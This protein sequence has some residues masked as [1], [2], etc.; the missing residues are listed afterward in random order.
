MRFLHVE[1]D[2]EIADIVRRILS[3]KG[4]VH[5]VKNTRQA[6]HEIARSE[7]ESQKYDIVLLDLTLESGSDPEA[8]LSYMVERDMKV[9]I[10][11]GS[12]STLEDVLED[13][14]LK[15]V[16]YML[17][18]FANTSDLLAKID[19]LYSPPSATPKSNIGALYCIMGP[20]CAGKSAITKRAIEQLQQAGIPSGLCRKMTS[21]PLRDSED[22]QDFVGISAE[23]IEAQKGSSI[24]CTYTHFG[25]KYGIPSSINGQ[26][27]NGKNIFLIVPNF[28]VIDVLS[29][30]KSGGNLASSP[31]PILLWDD[32]EVLNARRSHA[33]R[34]KDEIEKRPVALLREQ[35]AGFQESV[36]A[37]RFLS[38]IYSGTPAFE[39]ENYQAEGH[40]SSD[41]EQ[42]MNRANFVEDV[43]ELQYG[44]TRLVSLVRYDQHRRT[45][46]RRFAS[47]NYKYAQF[48]KDFA[49][50]VLRKILPRGFSAERNAD[51][52]LL[53]PSGRPIKLDVSEEDY[54][55][56][57]DFA[58]IIPELAKSVVDKSNILFCS[59]NYG[60]AAIFIERYNTITSDFSYGGGR[61]LILPLIRH[62]IS[63]RSGDDNLS[64]SVL[65]IAP[66]EVNSDTMY[67]KHSPFA[68][69]TGRGFRFN[70]GLFYALT[71]RPGP[72]TR[73][74]RDLYSVAVCFTTRRALNPRGRRGI[75]DKIFG[76]ACSAY[77]LDLLFGKTSPKGKDEQKYCP[78]LYRRINR[79]KAES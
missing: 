14:A 29:S 31:L 11:T 15:N 60:R 21:R 64:N 40:S 61:D 46:R 63:S 37:G 48:H 36:K 53:V 8:L 22:K 65:Q 68:L 35:I 2:D 33:G 50:G 73:S 71:D 57:S 55:W 56:L 26:L 49:N 69:C 34:P 25:E 70:D 10:I 13:D 52:A 24:L 7:K 32:L 75:P 38:V 51:G 44:I 23:E 54:L 45:V 12:E 3:Q 27:M 6:R 4:E 19:A 16:P 76:R 28:E 66:A 5:V 79:L 62:I 67:Y 9:L 42:H 77:V 30:L 78:A 1:D 18:P 59:E 43:F 72:P 41:S 74:D 20:S 39:F 17:K 47:S 58:G